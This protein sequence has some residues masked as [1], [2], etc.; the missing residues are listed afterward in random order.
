[1]ARKSRQRLERD[2]LHGLLNVV[3][4]E[5]QKRKHAAAQMA[6]PVRIEVYPDTFVR[7][8]WFVQLDDGHDCLGWM[9]RRPGEPWNVGYRFKYKTGHRS[10][11]RVETSAEP[12][13]YDL[14]QIEAKL[15]LVFEEACKREH[16]AGH[17]AIYERL[18]IQLIGSEA[19][20]VV[21]D[22]PWA[23]QVDRE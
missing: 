23:K 12:S 5:V 17:T 2:H 10:G 1:M 9:T 16:A 22:M 8:I 21:A 15:S 19:Y 7:T 6:L 3:D 4:A 14:L 18:D 20:E 11:Y 13:E